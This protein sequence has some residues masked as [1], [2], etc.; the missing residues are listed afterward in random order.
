MLIGQFVETYE[1]YQEPVW[2]FWMFSETQKMLL[3][4]DKQTDRSFRKNLL[5]ASAAETRFSVTAESK[6]MLYIPLQKNTM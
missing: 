1:H 2:E 5:C 3:F 6:A 4:S